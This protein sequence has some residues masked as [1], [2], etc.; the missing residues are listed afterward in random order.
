LFLVPALIFAATAPKAVHDDRPRPVQRRPQGDSRSDAALGEIDIGKTRLRGG[1]AQ[2]SAGKT[3]RN[4]TQ[5]WIE[6]A[7]N[8]LDSKRTK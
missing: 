3:L 7:S 4:R 5:S 6:T 2:S 8:P 1:L